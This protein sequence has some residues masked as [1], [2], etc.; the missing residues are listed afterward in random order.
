MALFSLVPFDFKCR[1]ELVYL[2]LLYFILFLVQVQYS[3]ATWYVAHRYNEFSILCKFLEHQ[4][5]Y[6]IEFKDAESKFPPK[7]FGV[8]FRRSILEHRIAGLETFLLQFLKNG[9]LCSQ[10]AVDAL[11]SFLSVISSYH[12][13]LKA[14]LLYILSHFFKLFPF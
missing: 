11:L 13:I 2:I 8:A 4:S 6:T 5:P 3:G 12:C 7:A 9:K 1:I 14:P 10:N